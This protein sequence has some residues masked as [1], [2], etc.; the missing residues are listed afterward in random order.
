MKILREWNEL[1]TLPVAILLWF[2]IPKLLI[3]IDPEAGSY[4]I[5]V[6]NAFV[7]ATIGLYIGKTIVWLALK[8]GAP[9]VYRVLDDFLMNNKHTITIWQKGIFALSYYSLLLF[10]WVIILLAVT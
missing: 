7:L 1:L 8:I 9:D 3:Y 5:G 10:C 6:I 4:D 2:L